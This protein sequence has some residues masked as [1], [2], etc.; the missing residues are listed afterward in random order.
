MASSEYSIP[1]QPARFA[2]GK[3]E[4]NERML[5]ID[6]M[7][8]PSFLSGKTVLVTG[9][10]RGIGL[11]LVK[12]LLRHNANVIAT[13]RDAK[14]IDLP[15]QVIGDIDVTDDKCGDVLVSKLAGKQIDIL[16]NCA[17]SSCFSVQN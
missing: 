6:K 2:K 17:V 9:G 16:I 7:F 3:A 10:N 8:D 5:N 1:D 13:C 12:E 4:N 15:V 14:S 11:S